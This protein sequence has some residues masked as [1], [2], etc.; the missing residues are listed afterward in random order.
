MFNE[1][2]KLKIAVTSKCT[3]RC[4]HCYIN[5]N[6]NLEIKDKSI[7]RAV[8]MLFDS[9]GNFKKIE[10]YGGEPLL[11]YEKIPLWLEDIKK[12]SQK[13]RKKYAVFIATNGTLINNTIFKTIKEHNIFIAI[14]FSGSPKSHK[15]NR[16]TPE[17]KNSYFIVKDNIKKLMNYFN[18]NIFCIYCIDPSFTYNIYTDFKK[19]TDLGFETLN[20]ECVCGKK[21]KDKNYTELEK[22]I[23]KI[24]DEILNMIMRGRFIYHEQMYEIFSK[25][26]NTDIIC[27]AY[28]DLELYPDGNFGFYPYSFINYEKEKKK[29]TVGNTQSGFNKKYINCFYNKEN[30]IECL[31]K[32]Y[33]KKN[34]EDGSKALKI[35]DQ[36]VTDFS[37]YL[38]EK[39]TEN[40]KIRDYIK[41]AI[42]IYRKMYER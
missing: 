27:P 33:Y 42:K 37:K 17:G 3:L 10:F 9:E 18:E 32:Y 19:I 26:L 15:Y 25:N 39:S 34:L 35:R 16:I 21:W 28:T 2:K 14:S 31:K 6:S 12:I 38:I 40:K 8:E 29:I 4:N 11:L 22:G 13:H 23:R 24:N 7:K 30:C 20:I 41:K 5:K 1:I 36:V